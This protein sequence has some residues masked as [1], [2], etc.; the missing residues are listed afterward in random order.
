MLFSVK[1]NL[2]YFPSLLHKLE[3]IT[4]YEAAAAR[5][6]VSKIQINIAVVPIFTDCRFNKK[7]NKLPGKKLQATDGSNTMWNFFITLQLYSHTMTGFYI[8]Q[9]SFLAKRILLCDATQ[10]IRTLKQEF[11]K[12]YSCSKKRKIKLWKSSS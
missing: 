9:L 7:E 8:R 4:A 6:N 10:K 1:T 3:V 12:I 11:R 2:F 5:T